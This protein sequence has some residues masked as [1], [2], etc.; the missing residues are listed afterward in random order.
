M[1][2]ARA[3]APGCGLADNATFLSKY[4]QARKPEPLHTTPPDLWQWRE[5]AAFDRFWEAAA[6][7][8]QLE[9]TARKPLK[10]LDVSRA[11]SQRIDNH[12][13]DCQHGGGNDCLHFCLPGVVDLWSIE[14]Q[15][16][17][18]VRDR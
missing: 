4:S 15:R 13:G 8:E 10:V 2:V 18:G 14:L 17:M 3:V 16:A 7:R 1:H 11:T 6:A 9:L 12:C 5:F